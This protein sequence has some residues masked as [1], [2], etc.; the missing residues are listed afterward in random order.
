V[1]LGRTRGRVVVFGVDREI[2][3]AV[4]L[5]RPAD[6]PRRSATPPEAL[7]ELV[8]PQMLVNI[9]PQR[10]SPLKRFSEALK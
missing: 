4:E 1:D 5:Q 6:Q 9:Y 8:G 3:L 2:R 10:N 7:D